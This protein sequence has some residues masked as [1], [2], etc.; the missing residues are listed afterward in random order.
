MIRI[1]P[2]SWYV[3][4]DHNLKS[5]KK[6]NP[7]IKRIFNHWHR[8][9]KECADK[10]LK[11]RLGFEFGVDGEFFMP[12]KYAK[13]HFWRVFICYVNFDPSK[14]NYITND[15]EPWILSR[16]PEVTAAKGNLCL[17]IDNHAQLWIICILSV[18]WELFCPVA[19]SPVRNNKVGM[20]FLQNT[21]LSEASKFQ[22]ACNMINSTD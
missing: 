8:W 17:V 22:I 18:T 9:M 11:K 21:L 7:I 14:V 5:L 1:R 3:L 20:W 10:E 16:G 2:W 15:T 12:L 13:T 4:P 6:S 19:A